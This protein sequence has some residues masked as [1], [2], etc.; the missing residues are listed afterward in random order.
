MPLSDKIDH[1]KRFATVQPTGI[2]TLGGEG[3]A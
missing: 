1:G 3:E 2:L